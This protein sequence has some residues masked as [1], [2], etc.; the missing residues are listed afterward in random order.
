[1]RILGTTNLS[2]LPLWLGRSWNRSSWKL[3][4]MEFGE[5]IQ[6]RQHGIIE[7]CLT[8]PNGLL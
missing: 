1:M 3:R 4:H 8:N 6:D 5:M 7:G 2:A